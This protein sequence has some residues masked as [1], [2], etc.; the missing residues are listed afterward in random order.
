MTILLLLLLGVGA[1]VGSLPMLADP[2]GTPLGM[3]Q[4]VLA[5][6]PFHSYFVP[7][8]VLLVANGLLPFGVTVLAFRRSRD[9]GW[10]V[11]VQGAILTG[12]IV[13]EC[14]FL[15][16]V[17][18]PHYLYAAWGILLLAGGLALRDDRTPQP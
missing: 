17:V 16:M 8:L 3:S 6:S 5:H 7:G 10:W 18:W 12:W 14:I 15:R 13:I 4:S 9:Y 11:A 1:L 2:H